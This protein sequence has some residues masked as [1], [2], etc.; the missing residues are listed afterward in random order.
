MNTKTEKPII[1]KIMVEN[2][3]TLAPLPGE[4]SSVKNSMTREN[5]PQTHYKPKSTFNK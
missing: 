4:K 1:K 5:G 2:S 3:W